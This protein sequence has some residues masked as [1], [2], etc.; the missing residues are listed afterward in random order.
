MEDAAGAV[1]EDLEWEVGDEAVSD[2]DKFIGVRPQEQP[3]EE[4]PD[5][6]EEEKEKLTIT[7][8]DLTGGNVALKSFNKV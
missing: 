7:G 5:D 8:E 1:S 6:A 4:S 3:S 2:E